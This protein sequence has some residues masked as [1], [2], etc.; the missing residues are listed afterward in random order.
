MIRSYFGLQ[1]SPF[2]AESVT[3]LPHQQEIARRKLARFTAL[4]AQPSHGDA[5]LDRLPQALDGALQC[6][7]QAQF[8]GQHVGGSARKHTQ[9]YACGDDS[10]RH[11]VNGSIAAQHQDQVGAGGDGIAREFGGVA[12][13]LGGR[14]RRDD[15]YFFQGINGTLENTRR[16][17]PELARDRIVDQDRLLIFGDFSSITSP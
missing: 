5:P 8:V 13:R 1:R 11:F 6:I 2:D 4:V 7:A 9:R 14:Q 16:L 17:P 10:V 12:R 3:L 15:A